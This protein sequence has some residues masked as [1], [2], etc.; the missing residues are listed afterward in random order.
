MSGYPHYLCVGPQE[1]CQRYLLGLEIAVT[2]FYLS[3]YNTP[4]SEILLVQYMWCNIT[5]SDDK[6]VSKTLTQ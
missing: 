3:N 1:N 6:S 2:L 4:L 5:V